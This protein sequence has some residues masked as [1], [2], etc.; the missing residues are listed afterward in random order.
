M[1]GYSY[2][3]YSD[4]SDILKFIFDSFYCPEV[5]LNLL[6]FDIYL[7]AC[8]I[9]WLCSLS[10]QQN[11]LAGKMSSQMTRHLSDGSGQSTSSIAKIANHLAILDCKSRYQ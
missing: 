1:S 11:R 7:H 3:R 10:S 6:Q 8:L 4:S 9:K 2:S 5:F